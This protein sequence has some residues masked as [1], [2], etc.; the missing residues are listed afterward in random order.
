MRA[1]LF[2]IMIASTPAE[3]GFA[4]TARPQEARAAPNETDEIIGYIDASVELPRISQTI[5]TKG[6]RPIGDAIVAI[7]PIYHVPITYEDTFYYQ[8]RDVKTF[9]PIRPADRISSG[10]LPNELDIRFIA[11]GTSDAKQSWSVPVA[12][13]LAARAIDAMLDAYARAHGTRTFAVVHDATAIHVIATD[14][15][16]IHGHRQVLRPLLDTPLTIDADQ[17]SAFSVVEAICGEISI[18]RRPLYALS[19]VIGQLPL[20]ERVTIHTQRLPGRAILADVLRQA[21][22]NRISWHLFCGPFEEGCALNLH[23]VEQTRMVPAQ[24]RLLP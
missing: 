17:K 15:V 12:L 22:E 10:A 19:A 7:E 5:S 9:G 2:A 14:Y 21:H 6:G 18:A 8:A 24:N 13:A 1:M 23:Y 20:P 4:Q 3:A 16:D 11:P